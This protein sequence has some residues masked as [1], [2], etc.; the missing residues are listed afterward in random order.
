MPRIITV[1]SLETSA[2]DWKIEQTISE[3]YTECFN[4]T[5]PGRIS[6]HGYS[7]SHSVTSHLGENPRILISVVVDLDYV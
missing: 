3:C 4:K 7:S 5:K 1:K 2:P 6:G